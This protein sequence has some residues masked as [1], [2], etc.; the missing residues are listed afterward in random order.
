[1]QNSSSH[2]TSQYQIWTTFSFKYRATNQQSNTET[3]DKIRRTTTVA[4][5]MI[6]V[7]GEVWLRRR[8]RRCA[9][10]A[11]AVVDCEWLERPVTNSGDKATTAA[12]ACAQTGQRRWRRT[13]VCSGGGGWQRLGSSGV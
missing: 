4:S 8:Q 10:W 6:T 3:N 9:D 12:E 7:V 1:M 13:A 2:Q 5:C 11:T